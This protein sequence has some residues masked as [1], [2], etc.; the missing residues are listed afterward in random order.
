MRDVTGMASRGSFTSRSRKDSM[1]RTEVQAKIIGEKE[2]REY[3]FLVD[4]GAT[5]VALPLE[6]VEDLENLGF[7]VNPLIRELGPVPDDVIHP[8]FLL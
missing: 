1:G 5:H 3:A 8:P 2:T 7:R 4:T 6:E